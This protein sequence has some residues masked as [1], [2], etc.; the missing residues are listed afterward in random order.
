MKLPIKVGMLLLLAL[1]GSGLLFAQKQTTVTYLTWYTQ[2][3]EKILMDAF[4][5]ANPD[6]K[7]EV[8]GIDGSK[9]MEI[10]KPRLAAGDVSDVITT[11]PAVFDIIKKDA[12]LLDL[13]GEPLMA[14]QNKVPALKDAMTYNGKVYGFVHEAGFQG[15]VYY[16]KLLLQKLGAKVP[17]TI[18]EYEAILA[19]AKT[20]GI[21][22]IIYGG[23]DAW[24]LNMNG[25]YENE[26]LV[27]SIV[28]QKTGGKTLDANKAFFD[29]TLKPS[30]YYQPMME[31]QKKYWDAG[32][33][34]KNSRSFTWPESF[35][36]FA[37]GNAVFFPQGPWVPG[38]D[39][40]KNADPAKL[41]LGCFYAPQK[42]LDGK[43][44]LSTSIS[45]L[46]AIYAKTK[47]LAASRKLIN[48]LGSDAALKLYYEYRGLFSP[49]PIAYNPPAIF[50]DVVKTIDS[51]KPIKFIATF[52]G[53]PGFDAGP[54]FQNVLAGGPIADEL[55]KLD[56]FYAEHKADIK[57]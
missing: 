40:A 48:W 29:G 8:E 20:A 19:K 4:M 3:E 55:K 21:D 26:S 18:A 6:V 9:Y 56:A 24:V 35:A 7:V 46:L 47:N 41:Q 45:K 31:R 27:T 51:L 53:A 5:K 2:G 32:W 25:Q 30:E 34:S 49:Y 10:L 14:L 42:T 13:S 38:M 36:Y 52:P 39:E 54:S 17:T 11:L 28:A 1:A 12:Q 22:P 15:F 57:Q 50:S 37:A 44:Y 16:N 43:Y 33:I 23:K